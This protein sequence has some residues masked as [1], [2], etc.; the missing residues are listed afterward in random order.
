ADSGTN[1]AQSA[2]TF[3]VTDPAP[4]PCT[5]AAVADPANASLQFAV[6]S[7][8]GAIDITATPS[9]CASSV[10][11]D[12]PSWLSFTNN[13][14]NGMGTHN[15]TFTVATNVQVNQ[16]SQP[17]T[18]NLVVSGTD[19]SGKTIF[20]KSFAVK[21]DGLQCSFTPGTVPSVAAAGIPASQ[22]LSLA[23]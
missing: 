22:A 11:N 4:P 9:T 6:T 8:A 7:G 1:T 3:S 18:A 21:Q 15:A 13:S 20:T 23:V 10:S 2:G 16:S 14:Q 5:F 19:S 12:S 17:R